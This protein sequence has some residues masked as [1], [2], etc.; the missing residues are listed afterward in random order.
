M[1]IFVN[2][3]IS[4]QEQYAF[5]HEAILEFIQAGETEIGSSDLHNYVTNVLTKG[6]DDKCTFL[7]QRQYQV[8]IR[9]GHHLAAV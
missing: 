8:G 5:C 3:V 9:C 7:L 6:P 4:K 1:I 2:V